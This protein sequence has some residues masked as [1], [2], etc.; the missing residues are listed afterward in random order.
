M[1]A[2]IVRYRVQA[3]FAE[4]NR[5]NIE[6]VLAEH[7]TAG[8]PGVRYSVHNEDP[9]TFVHIGMY[10][11]DAAVEAA[12]ELASFKAF[13]AALRASKPEAPPKATWLETIGA[14]F[15]VFAG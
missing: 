14:G 10:A 6:R 4:Q 7:R 3:S 8:L 2:V 9:Q 13:Q 15:E 12:T 11:D 5:A 1:K